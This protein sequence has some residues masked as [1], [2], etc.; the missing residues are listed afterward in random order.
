MEAIARQA[1]AADGQC[2]AVH[3]L[4]AAALGSQGRY[5]EAEPEVQAAIR[6]SPKTAQEVFRGWQD[7]EVSF[8]CQ[9]YARLYVAL[10]RSVGLQAF[11]VLVGSDFQDVG[12]AHACA[13][14]TMPA[15]TVAWPSVRTASIWSLLVGATASIG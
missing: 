4:L 8:L 13:G 5:E 1:V 12:L 7:P 9:E 15:S 3:A 6:L 14:V 2:A 11:F 10:A